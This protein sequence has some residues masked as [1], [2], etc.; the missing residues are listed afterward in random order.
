MNRIAI[1][2]NNRTDVEESV[3]PLL[4]IGKHQL[5][6]LHSRDV[7]VR[8]NVASERNLRSADCVADDR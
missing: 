2:P 4:F 8:H 3:S 6:M 7:I 5:Q 1:K